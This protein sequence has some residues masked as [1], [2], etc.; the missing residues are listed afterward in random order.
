VP[1]VTPTPKILQLQSFIFCKELWLTDCLSVCLS[2]CVCVSVC[3][4]LCLSLSVSLC[5]S[6]SLSLSVCVCVRACVRACARILHLH[7][8]C[9]CMW[10]PL[11]GVI[12]LFKK[13]KRCMWVHHHCPQTHQKRTSDPIAVVMSHRVIARNWTQDLWKS[14]RRSSSPATSFKTRYLTNLELFKSLRLVR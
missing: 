7:I 4:S 10:R 6:V 3:L 8:L 12:H 11:S 13:K 14:S 5:L 1:P 9:L 2:V